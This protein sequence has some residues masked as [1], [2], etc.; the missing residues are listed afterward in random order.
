MTFKLRQESS[1]GGK[2]VSSGK[3]IKHGQRLGSE[4][5]RRGN[6][7]ILTC[8]Q[9]V[10]FRLDITMQLLFTLPFTFKRVLTGHARYGAFE[11][12]EVEREGSRR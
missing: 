10:M 11:K 2:E 9:Q 6:R 7:Y 1:E 5:E 8:P 12:Y 3:R 4:K